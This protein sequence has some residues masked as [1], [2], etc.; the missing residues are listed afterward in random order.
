M[1]VIM[2]SVA[3]FLS[4]IIGLRIKPTA[5]VVGSSLP[6]TIVV[7]VFLDCFADPTNHNLWPF[8]LLAATTIGVIVAFPSAGIGWIL[9]RLTNA[10]PKQ[11]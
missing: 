5:L 4:W 11:N 1:F 10:T 9:R 6:A 3:V 7:R 8:E 2:A